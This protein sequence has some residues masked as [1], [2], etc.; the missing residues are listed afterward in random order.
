M[1]SVLIHPSA[2]IS[3]SARLGNDVEIGPHVIIEGAVVIGDRTR[4]Q[5][6][7]V[8]TGDVTLGEDNL[9]GYSAIIGADPQDLNYKA[10][11]PSGVVIGNKNTIRELCT[12]HCGSGENTMTRVGDGNYLMAGTHLAHNV[13]MGN[14]CISAN[15]VLLAGHV[16]V[17]DKVFLGGA[18]CFHQFVRIGTMA[19]TQGMSGIGKDVP[20]Y[21]MT[22]GRNLVVGLN[23]VGM[24]RG[25]LKAEQRS[26][27]K[28]AFR[29]LYRSGLN[30]SQALEKA[31]ER[32]WGTEAAY[33]FQFVREAKKRGICEG[34]ESSRREEAEGE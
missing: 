7:A 15:N 26:E 14:Q 17:E 21:S 19:V 4:I 5:G 1:S 11:T 32:T 16:R 33:F 22:A 18:G 12:I 23:V 9:V 30:V 29:L 27:I 8:I 6:N 25:G 3:P 20:P 28:E 24:R 34:L 2:I 13:I 31:A 10:G